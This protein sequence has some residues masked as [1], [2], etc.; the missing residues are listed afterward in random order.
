MVT[1]YALTDKNLFAYCDNNPVMRVDGDGEFW[2]ISIGIGFV[3]QYVGDVIENLI[4]GKTGAD[5][6][7]PTSSIGEYIAA[8]LTALIPGTGVG[9]A[10]IR[11]IITE[12]ITVVEDV[13]LENEVDIVDS[14]IEVGVGTVLDV[15]FETVSNKTVNFISSKQPRN[16][17][18]FAHKARQSNANLTRE[19]IYHSMQR[20]IRFNRFISK[21]AA[22]GFGI[23]REQFP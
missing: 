1:P 5:I 4:D 14:M 3:T 10:L 18:S 7:K 20:S 17:S 8:G 9:S 2:L 11:N 23:A 15:G 12:G 13:I 22:F 16:Y 6:F 21:S 19:Q